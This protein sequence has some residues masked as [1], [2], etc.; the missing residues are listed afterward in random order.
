MRYQTNKNKIDQ[1]K[2]QKIFAEVGIYIVILS[3]IGSFIL[4]LMR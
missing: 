1:H 2:K 3:I 4:V